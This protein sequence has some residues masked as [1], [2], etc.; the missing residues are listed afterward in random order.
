MSTKEMINCQ[1][2]VMGAADLPNLVSFRDKCKEIPNTTYVTHGLHSYPAKLIPHIPRYFIKKSQLSKSCGYVLDPFCGSGTTLVEAKL[3]GWNSFGVDINPFAKLLSKVKTTQLDTKKLKACFREIMKHILDDKA[4]F[5]MPKFPDINYWFSPRAQKK[6][7]IIKEA[8]WKIEEPDYRDFFKVCFSAI[9][10]KS[11]YADP[12]I[13][14]ACKSKRMRTLIQNGWEPSVFELFRKVTSY[15]ISQH[16]AFVEKCKSQVFAKVIGKNA[17]EVMLK[18]EAVDLV[19]TSPPYIN[20]Q[21]Y[22]RSTKLEI[23]WLN[24]MTKEEL[25]ELDRELIGTERA[26]FEEYR[27]LDFSDL[28]NL[29]QLNLTL[30]NLSK[31]DRRRAYI[32]YKYFSEMDEV[33]SEIHR[34]LK[35]HE[36]FVLVIGNNRFYG[37][38]VPTSEIL[39]DMAKEHLFELQTAYIDTIKSRGLMTKRNKTAAMINCEWVLVFQRLS[40]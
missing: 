15:N 36:C 28:T 31:I 17:K 40:D 6:L 27:D 14:P 9:V 24:L 34:V 12:R 11:S 29:N 20:A 2:R 30:E 10:R 3:C 21:K 39:V 26:K 37:K 22:V 23:Y 13:S 18:D 5:Q 38:K 4:K 7:M 25:R 1:K 16:Q 8:I 33:F 32:V 35:Y 19:I